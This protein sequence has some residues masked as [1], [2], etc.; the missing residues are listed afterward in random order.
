MACN[1]L[2]SEQKA[3]LFE[4]KCLY[5][6]SRGEALS[7]EEDYSRASFLKTGDSGVILQNQKRK[8]QRQDTEQNEWEQRCK[9]AHIAQWRISLAS[10]AR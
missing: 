7:D 1:G 9:L 3:L 4:V 5:L 10:L 2:S 6:Y 8:M